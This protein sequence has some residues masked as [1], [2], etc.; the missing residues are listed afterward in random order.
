MWIATPTATRLGL[1]N[2]FFD[3]RPSH[4]TPP[5]AAF[6]KNS[7]Q[8]YGLWF[9]AINTFMEWRS[10]EQSLQI[11]EP[12]ENG[13]RTFQGR[14]SFGALRTTSYWLTAI[15]ATLIEAYMKDALTFA[16]S[17]DSAIM[18][19]PPGRPPSPLRSQSTGGAASATS[20]RKWARAWLRSHKGPAKW[21]QGFEQLGVSGF[22]QHLDDRLYE[23][24]G[25]RHLVVHSAGVVDEEYL[26]HHPTSPWA[27]GAEASIDE[28]MLHGFVQTTFEFFAPIEAHLVNRFIRAKP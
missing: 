21:I 2:E 1:G 8:L 12:D 9:F 27:V 26:R 13:L 16:A 28:G 23:L 7:E 17:M 18:Q 11:G 15:L 14:A 5:G 4:I 3:R 19:M 25:V 20:A 24:L 22:T 10:R 6:L